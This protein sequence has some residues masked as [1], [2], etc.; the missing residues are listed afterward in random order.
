ME[1]NP[2]GPVQLYATPEVGELPESVTDDIVQVSGPLTIA[3]IPGSE[4]F[5]ITSVVSFA[6]HPFSGFVTVNV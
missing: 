4:I 2:P 5:C 1:V 3:E 6:T